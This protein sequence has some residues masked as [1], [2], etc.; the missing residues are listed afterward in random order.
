MASEFEENIVSGNVNWSL[1]I[2]SAVSPLFFFLY[3]KPYTLNP[4]SF[5]LLALPTLAHF[6]H[7]HLSAL[8]L[9]LS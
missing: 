2:V 1:K 6:S 5:Y 7:F 8:R 4:I 9:Q 3:L